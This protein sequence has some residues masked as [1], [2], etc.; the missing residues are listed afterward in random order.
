LRAADKGE[1]MAPAAVRRYLESKFGDH[2]QD[3][4]QA[5]VEL[6]RSFPPKELTDRAFALYE[7]FR[8]AVPKGEKGWGVAGELDL[9]LLSRLQRTQ[10]SR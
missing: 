6:A 4:R 8:P 7:A 2:L 3:V 5:M 10:G 9:A 1:A